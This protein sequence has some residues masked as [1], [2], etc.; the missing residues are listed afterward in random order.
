[1]LHISKV[2]LLRNS[3]KFMITPTIMFIITPKGIDLAC[4]SNM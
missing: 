1:M 3:T 4:R 2:H